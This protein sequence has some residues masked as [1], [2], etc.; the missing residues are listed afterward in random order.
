MK[1]T[2]EQLL[3]EYDDLATL[4]EALPRGRCAS[5]RPEPDA[6]ETRGVSNHTPPSAPAVCFGL[7]VTEDGT[8]M[9]RIGRGPDG[10]AR[11]S[12]WSCDPFREHAG[13]RPARWRP[14]VPSAGSSRSA[15]DR[16]GYLEAELGE[17]GL[18]ST[19]VLMLATRNADPSA[20][21]GFEWGAVTGD[22]QRAEVRI[23]PEGGPSYY[24]AVLGYWDDFVE[25]IRDGD[26][27]ME[28][29]STWIPVQDDA[30]SGDGEA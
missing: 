15:R 11:V 19:Y 26:R 27:W 22:T 23:F 8:R 28:P 1:P 25:A 10:L 29:L 7:W 16:I 2:L 13:E 12:V 4:A 14:P 18:G 5:L 20:C 30:L 24:E 17:P 6:C 21:G 9:M 3:G